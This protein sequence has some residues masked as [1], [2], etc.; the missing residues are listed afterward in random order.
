MSPPQTIFEINASSRDLSSQVM[1]AKRQKDRKCIASFRQKRQ[2]QQE[3]PAIP[4]LSL[5]APQEEQP[6]KEEA[7]GDSVEVQA[8][9]WGPWRLAWGWGNSGSSPS[10]PWGRPQGSEQSLGVD[11]VIP[12]PSPTLVEISDPASASPS[13]E[14]DHSLVHHSLPEALGA[15]C[16]SGFRIF[17]VGPLCMM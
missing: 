7:A 11:A 15:R 16:D 2:E 1:R 4:A 12:V 14:W 10:S 3:G 6:E 5:P 17:T 8:P 13:A 9:P